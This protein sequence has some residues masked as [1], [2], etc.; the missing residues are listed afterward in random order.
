MAPY[1]TEL[2]CDQIC[3][4]EGEVNCMPLL[5]WRTV[6]PVFYCLWLGIP[7]GCITS[8]FY[9]EKRL[10]NNENGSGHRILRVSL[11][12]SKHIQSSATSKIIF[13]FFEFL[14]YQIYCIKYFQNT[15]YFEFYL[16]IRHLLNVS[17]NKKHSESGRLNSLLEVGRLSSSRVA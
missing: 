10:V 14:Y 16:K 7:L 4:E 8:Y 15:H 17:Q 11:L 2:G 9:S 3:P 6:S 5:C 13:M 12:S 1:L